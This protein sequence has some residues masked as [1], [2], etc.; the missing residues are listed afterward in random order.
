MDDTSTLEEITRKIE[1]E[2]NKIEDIH[3]TRVL[4]GGD[5]GGEVTQSTVEIWEKPPN[6]YRKKVL[7]NDPEDGSEG[8]IVIVNGSEMGIY[9][10]KHDNINVY[11]NKENRN[12]EHGG[13]TNANFVLNMLNGP[14]DVTREGTTTI[15][16]RGAY[17]LLLSPTENANKFHQQYISIEICL[18]QERL[19]PLKTSYDTDFHSSE[20]II[21]TTNSFKKVEFDTGYDDVVFDIDSL[22]ST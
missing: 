13:V 14:F 7:S 4:H 5:Q 22:K 3:G 10:A 20:S 11:E 17:V 1:T 9:D 6:K 12:E 16:D 15:A 21:S 18:D 8:H 19:Y 2:Y